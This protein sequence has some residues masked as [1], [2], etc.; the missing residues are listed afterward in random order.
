MT[1]QPSERRSHKP[2]DTEDWPLDVWESQEGLC[3]L[4]RQFSP[5]RPGSWSLAIRKWMEVFL[6]F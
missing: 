3:S 5:S 6:V 1:V 2:K 4:Q